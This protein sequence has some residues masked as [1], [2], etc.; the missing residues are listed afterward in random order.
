MNQGKMLNGKKTVEESNIEA[1]EMSLS[2]LSGMEK[3][4]TDEHNRDRRRKRK[5]KKKLEELGEGKSIRPSE[6]AVF[7]KKEIIDAI[8][9]SD[10]KLESFSQR[11]DEKNYTNNH[12]LSRNTASWNEHNHRE[13]ERRK[14]G[15]EAT[16]QGKNREHGKEVF[17]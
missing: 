2:V 17:P 7:V 12:E 11:T 1:I 16:N 3:R 9:R 8:R 14:R 6:D 5:E 10:D 13:N 4:R 15:K